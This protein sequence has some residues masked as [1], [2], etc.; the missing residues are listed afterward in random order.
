M[1]SVAIK[2]YV[3]DMM[4]S[5]NKPEVL[6]EISSF[7]ENIIHKGTNEWSLRKSKVHSVVTKSEGSRLVQSDLVKL[8]T[9]ANKIDKL[10]KVNK[11]KRWL[12]SDS[13]I[14]VRATI[15]YESIDATIKNISESLCSAAEMLKKDSDE[16][17]DSA[18]WLKDQI[19]D[20]NNAIAALEEAI[21]HL[22]VNDNIPIND[23][24][25][26]RLRELLL[27]KVEDLKII[28]TAYEQFIATISQTVFNNNRQIQTAQRMSVVI[29][30]VAAAG[31]IVRVAMNR[32]EQVDALNRSAKEF[33]ATLISQNA[34]LLEKQ[35]IAS[36]EAYND[37]SVI[38]EA[39]K[40]AHLKLVAAL[41]EETKVN[42][43]VA[44]TA[45]RNVSDLDKLNEE[46][47]NRLS[48]HRPGLSNGSESALEYK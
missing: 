13:K 41:E 4:T 27:I 23:E 48:S 36:K 33:T 16:L 15:R 9:Q 44:E 31:F 46:L 39:L 29:G 6:K 28:S 10:T 12:I 42:K 35:T 19:V 24:E 47:E 8:R 40:G 25:K 11:L 2:S 17:I 26:N 22:E 14:V 30:T 20:I 21:H 5:L 43:E 1:N 7:G 3:G 18:S 34:E 32:Q 38:V 45:M 37:S